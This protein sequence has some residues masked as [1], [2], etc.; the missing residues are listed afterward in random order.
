MFLGSKCGTK[1]LP[2]KRVAALLS[3]FSFYI[4]LRYTM[5]AYWVGARYNR[6]NE[7]AYFV[8]LSGVGGVPFPDPPVPPLQRA[9]GEAGRPGARAV[10]TDAGNQGYAAG[11]AAAHSRTGYPNANPPP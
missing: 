3:Y 9:S 6:R 10:S 11:G 2:E 8:G 1:Q 7:E 5:N 4:V